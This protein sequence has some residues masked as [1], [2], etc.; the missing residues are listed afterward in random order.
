MNENLKK[1]CNR[2]KFD[3]VDAHCIW[4]YCI[5]LYQIYTVLI[6]PPQQLQYAVYL[7]GAKRIWPLRMHSPYRQHCSRWTK[8][9]MKEIKKENEERKPQNGVECDVYSTP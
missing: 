7:E 2:I 1:N 5:T 6:F 9:E 8:R 3:E 4:F